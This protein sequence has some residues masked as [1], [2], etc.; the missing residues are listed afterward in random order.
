MN[1]KQ[2]YQTIKKRLA[3]AP[4]D[5]AKKK[6]IQELLQAGGAEADAVMQL[7]HRN[8]R[9]HESPNDKAVAP[10]HTK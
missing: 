1:N 8:P 5:A 4:D 9:K 3:S 7:A 2:L 6:I 10:L